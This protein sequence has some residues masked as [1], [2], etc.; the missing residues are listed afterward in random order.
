MAYHP[1]DFA[2]QGIKLLQEITTK[3]HENK[4]DPIKIIELIDYYDPKVRKLYNSRLDWEDKDYLIKNIELFIIGCIISIITILG[5][6]V[7]LEQFEIYKAPSLNTTMQIRGLAILMYVIQAMY[8]FSY[9]LNRRD[10]T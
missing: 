10:V 4:S 8:L 5:V 1:A 7:V 2:R 3:F 6:V 9:I